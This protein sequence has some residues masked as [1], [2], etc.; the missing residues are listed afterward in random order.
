MKRILLAF[1]F[2]C[3]CRHAAPIADLL[4]VPDP[5]LRPELV[6]SRHA[7]T[8]ERIA[9]FRAT[10]TDQDDPLDAFELVL[11]A[12][13]GGEPE[14]LGGELFHMAFTP[15]PAWSPDGER[16]AIVQSPVDEPRST[17]VLVYDPP[18]ATPTTTW[19]L[20][21]G[22]AIHSAP[23]WS[24][25]G[26]R[27]AIPINDAEGAR[28]E[29]VTLADGSSRTARIASKDWG[30]TSASFSPDGRELAVVGVQRL[31][32]FDARTC[33]PRH[34][35][36]LAFAGSES[37]TP[38]VWLPQR[39]LVVRG[40]DALWLVDPAQRADRRLFPTHEIVDV[41]LQP[42]TA[43]I[44]A[45]ARREVPPSGVG[46]ALEVVAGAGHARDRYETIGLIFDA[47]I[48]H[49]ISLESTRTLGSEVDFPVD[50]PLHPSVRQALSLWR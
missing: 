42:G 5:G 50:P 21:G 3:G 22:G 1:V 38:P 11:V 37:S 30:W 39:K 2:V 18:G 6:S 25:D 14:R 40:G 45:V 47:D 12:A 19:T 29:V 4:P 8:G 23:A 27:L 13:S 7:P 10:A 20:S 9:A 26:G 24:P 36:A 16:V 34:E 31:A 17:R 43:Q 33:E 44:L 15:P 35:Q 32:L 41:V 46:G 49:S 28:V 48:S